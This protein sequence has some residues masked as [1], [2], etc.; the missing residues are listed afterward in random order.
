MKK[1]IWLFIFATA[2]QANAR[3]IIVGSTA[4]IIDAGAQA[5]AGDT[6]V[7]QSG[8]YR[9]CNLIISTKGTAS[10]PIV[11]MAQTAGSVYF[12]GN[13]YLHISGNYITVSGVV[14]KDGF[15]GKNHVWQ[16]SHGKEVANN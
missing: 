15:A 3:K 12:T 2:L 16:F 9:N 1:I 6:I 13:S 5:K 10:M 14:F 7:I 8:A 11:F 4:T